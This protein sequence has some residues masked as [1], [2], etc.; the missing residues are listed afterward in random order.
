MKIFQY[1]TTLFNN[2]IRAILVE[3]NNN[4]LNNKAAYFDSAIEDT[5]RK[6]TITR[7]IKEKNN[8]N[9]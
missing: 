3:N 1:N 9:K 6:F 8:V 5:I 7:T 2:E 4:D